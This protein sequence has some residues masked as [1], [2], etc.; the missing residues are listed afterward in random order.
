VNKYFSCGNIRSSTGKSYLLH[1]GAASIFGHDK[2]RLLSEAILPQT[3]FPAS[4]LM[5]KFL[6]ML[7][8]TFC[9]RLH[10]L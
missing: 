3:T 8:F 9:D 10:N 1:D 4:L 5:L 7:H 2:I 6:G